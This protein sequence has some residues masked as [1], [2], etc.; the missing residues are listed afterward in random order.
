MQKQNS[1]RASCFFGTDDLLLKPAEC[2]K[3]DSVAAGN[4]CKIVTYKG[5]EHS[6][7]NRQ[8]YTEKTLKEADQF[9]VGLGWLKPNK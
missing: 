6:F 5:Q 7:F 3:D 4:S 2:F 8:P 1:H 9:L